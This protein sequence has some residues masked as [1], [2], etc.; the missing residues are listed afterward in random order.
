MLASTLLVQ[1]G[2]YAEAAA[3]LANYQPD[4]VDSDF[5]QY[6]LA[7]DHICQG[8]DVEGRILLEVLLQRGGGTEPERAELYD[9]S[10][11]ALG[12]SYLQH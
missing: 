9:K 12:Y 7:L 10:R 6:N 1:R 3:Q 2:L 8:R 5:V 4:S 11:I